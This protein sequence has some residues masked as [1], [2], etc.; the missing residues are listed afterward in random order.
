MIARHAAV[1]LA[2]AA[3]LSAVA[4]RAVE[5][6]AYVDVARAVAAHPLHA[7]LAQYDREIAA[8]RA[9]LTVPT[10]GAPAV[11]ARAG[12]ATV[13]RAA[14]SAQPHLGAIAARP[15]AGD[16][17]LERDAIASAGSS[18][19]AADRAMAAYSA[20]LARETSASLAGYGRSIAER[21]ARALAARRQQLR[22]RE[23]TLAFDLAR[24]N[25]GRRLALRLK[26]D[27]LR[28]DR[29]DRTR[30]AA[31]LAAMNARESRA[32][33]AMRRDDAGLLAAYERKLHGDGTAEY[34]RMA[35]QLEAKSA[36]NLAT[37]RRVRSAGTNAPAANGLTQ[38]TA[39]FS[40]SY[41]PNADAQ[42]VADRLHGASVDISRRFAD[43][44]AAASGSQRETIAQIRTLQVNRDAL[45][46]SI[47][48]QIMREAVAAAKARNL[49]G[50]RAHAAR[51]R[52]G[53]DVT[54]AVEAALRRI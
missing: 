7:M 20:E 52:A 51:P 48:R 40:A 43:L 4:A 30:V 12:A 46:R 50:V 41:R 42:A 14:D 44:G 13:A 3:L 33:D 45:Y 27:D 16:R 47:V 34:A 49:P 38:Q 18:Q 36:A 32:V 39:A 22:E 11:Q 26:L 10:S 2:L 25:G 1:P 37:R 21:N 19:R 23:L 35:A 5:A 17:A 15:G 9:T 8:L 28:L 53:V 24:S 54:P 31:E 29:S 6:P